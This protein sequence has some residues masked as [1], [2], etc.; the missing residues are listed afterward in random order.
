MAGKKKHQKKNQAA[1]NNDNTTAPAIS[2]TPAPGPTSASVTSRYEELQRNEVIALEAIYGD[3]FELNNQ[4]AWNKSTPA[5]SIRIKAPSDETITVTLAVV[6][7]A[8]YPKSEPILKLKNQTNIKESTFFKLQKFLETQPAVFAKE[9]QEMVFRIVEGIQE[10]LQEAADAKAAGK[11]LPTLVEE[12]AAHE[13]AVAKMAEKQEL[14]EKNKKTEESKEEERHLQ[15]MLQGEIKRKKEMENE[16][17]KKARLHTVSFMSRSSSAS[18]DDVNI[19]FDQ[20][21]KLTDNTGHSIVFSAVT[22]KEELARGPV[23][24]VY[25]V[26]P[27]LQVAQKRPR[28]VLKQVRIDPVG[29]EQQ[30]RKQLGVLEDHL[31]F[32]QDHRHKA[33]VEVIGHRVDR[34]ADITDDGNAMSYN[35]MVLTPPT[36][37]CT[38]E[39]MLSWSVTLE[40]NRCRSFTVTLLDALTWLHSRNLTHGDIHPSN[41]LLVTEPTGDM[42]PK[43]ADVAF[44]RELHTM[45]K[46]GKGNTST[47]MASARSAYWFPPEIAAQSEIAA[48][49]SQK[50]DIWDFGLVFLQM[51]K[52]LD[53]AQKFQSP[54]EFMETLP[55]SESLADLVSSFFRTDPKKRPRAFDLS[56]SEFLATDAPVEGGSD[57]S[58][59][60]DSDIE[61]KPPVRGRPRANST[62]AGP[63]Q[64][65]YKKE[66]IEEARLGKGG[67]GEVVKA[68]KKMDGNFYGMLYWYLAFICPAILSSPVYQSPN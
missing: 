41:I 64:S 43:L 45:C 5:F 30:I 59:V 10:I 66:F 17:K 13:A 36:A 12:R 53:V 8:T 38:L 68:R 23:T 19:T 52:G 24:V 42:G 31:K 35:V 14:E 4:T 20:T 9:E 56:S 16:A 3:D 28:L 25:E 21:C 11:A 7:V 60:F 65:L 47:S 63:Y 54:K 15:D 1:A 55:L 67:F 6:L 27:V 29:K 46:T 18:N 51:I 62:T 39:R 32:L 49:Y 26:R 44:Q 61:S 50:T 58:G 40:I 57:D 37:D 33:I 48:Q 2:V 22:D 34:I